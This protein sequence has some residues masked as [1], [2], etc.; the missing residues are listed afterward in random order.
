[1]CADMICCGS[2][3]MQFGSPWADGTAS[4]SQCVINP[5][6]TFTY[7]FKVDKVSNGSWKVGLSLSRFLGVNGWWMSAGWDI[8]LPRALRNAK[9]SRVVRVSGCGRRRWQERAVPLRRRV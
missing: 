9:I 4:I 3:R 7:R 6:E 2:E 1:M 5:G 8:L